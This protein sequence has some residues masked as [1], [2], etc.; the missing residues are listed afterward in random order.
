MRNDFPQFDFD[1]VALLVALFEKPLER[2]KRANETRG[3]T[4][5]EFLEYSR[6]YSIILQKREFVA[7]HQ[8]H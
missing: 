1:E 6:R 3:G 2:L 8:Q 5:P 4:D 7:G